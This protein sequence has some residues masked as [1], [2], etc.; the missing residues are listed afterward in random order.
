MGV[1]EIDQLKPVLTIRVRTY[2]ILRDRL[3]ETI[4]HNALDRLIRDHWRKLG[5]R[6]ATRDEDGLLEYDLPKTFERD[7]VLF[8]WTSKQHPQSI[9]SVGLPK[10]TPPEW[11][12]TL[13]PHVETLEDQINPSDWPLKLKAE[14]PEAPLLFVHLSQFDDASCLAI[15]YPHALCDQFG[16]SN[17]MKAWL[18]VTR[19]EEPPPMLG[20]YEDFLASIEKFPETVLARRGRQRL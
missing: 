5:A 11:G 12:I 2:F 4:L 8:N 7:D 20:I 16:L 10:A 15:N 3:D 13:Q 19:G 1:S 9:T 14:L 18:N 17:I 6:L